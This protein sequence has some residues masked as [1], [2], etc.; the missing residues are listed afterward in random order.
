MEPSVPRQ[1]VQWGTASTNSEKSCCALLLLHAATEHCLGYVPC[2]TLPAYS[3]CNSGRA[4]YI[5]CCPAP[6]SWATPSPARTRSATRLQ[7]LASSLG[8]LAA[9]GALR[10]LWVPQL[11]NQ[12]VLFKGDKCSSERRSASTHEARCTS[13]PSLNHHFFNRELRCFRTCCV[14]LPTTS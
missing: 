8:L 12:E 13:S 1:R 14:S 3:T 4:G 2:P 11:S 6:T 9:T 7:L 10:P 5:C